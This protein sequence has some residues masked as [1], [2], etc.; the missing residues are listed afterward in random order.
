MHFLTFVINI[1]IACSD[2]LLYVDEE[3]GN[4][5]DDF[6]LSLNTQIDDGSIEQVIN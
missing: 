3:L 2:A 4:L 5:I 6:M 1:I